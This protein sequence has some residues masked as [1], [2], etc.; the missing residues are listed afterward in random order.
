MAVIDEGVRE[1]WISALRAQAGQLVLMRNQLREQMEAILEVTYW[2]P[3]RELR[4]VKPRKEF[5]R[6]VIPGIR[7]GKYTVAL[8]W[9]AYLPSGSG[10]A[11]SKR[12]MI[13]HRL[14]TR[15]NGNAPLLKGVPNVTPELK[16]IIRLTCRELSALD[17]TSEYLGIMTRA[18]L[19][20][21]QRYRVS[22]GDMEFD[23]EAMEAAEFGYNPGMPSEVERFR[24]EVKALRQ[25]HGVMDRPT[26]RSR[27]ADELDE[28]ID[29]ES[30][31]PMSATRARS[32]AGSILDALD[33][34]G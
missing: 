34:K 8:Q 21:M 31:E 25:K 4:K 16:E 13:P 11:K 17:S 9:T 10:S 26:R 28:Q 33:P 24:V 32:H 18:L 14:P 27:D 7:T 19:G 30:M 12:S 29:A 3:Y 22:A 20:M 23:D 2:G 1:V 15:K 5:I 6:P